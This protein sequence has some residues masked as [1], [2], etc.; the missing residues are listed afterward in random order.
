MCFSDFERIHF[1]VCIM[2]AES[3]CQIVL[4]NWRRLQQLS[5]PVD[6]NAVVVKGKQ[7]TLADVVAVARYGTTALIDQSPALRE[8]VDKSVNF[9][10]QCVEQGEILY[11]S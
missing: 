8:S 7:L 5:S 2:A 1:G 3:H 4:E 6:K 10:R 9:L 11:G